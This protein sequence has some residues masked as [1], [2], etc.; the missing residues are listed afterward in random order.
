MQTVS[1]KAIVLREKKMPSGGKMADL[2]TEGYGRLSCFISKGVLARC[3]TGTILP[4]SIIEGTLRLSEETAMLSQ[5]EGMYNGGMLDFSMEEMNAWYYV[6]EIVLQAYPPFQA[7]KEAFSVLE[8]A[9]RQNA[10]KDRILTAF[11]ASIR[12][13]ALAGFDPSAGEMAERYSLSEGARELLKIFRAYQFGEGEIRVSKN[14][15]AE[16]A[17]MLDHFIPDYTDMSLRMRGAFTDVFG[18]ARPSAKQTGSMVE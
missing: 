16:A 15:L 11:A 3:G 5:Y 2:F 14:Y 6:L 8:G 9:V 12:L 18:Q 10:R 7:D 1:S 13:L 17:Q 4:L